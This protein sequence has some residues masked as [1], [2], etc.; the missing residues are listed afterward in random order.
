MWHGTV[1]LPKPAPYP[2]QSKPGPSSP[3][4]TSLAE[5]ILPF[6]HYQIL[7]ILQ[8]LSQVSPPIGSL[9]R[10]LPT[11]PSMVNFYWALTVYKAQFKHLRC[12]NSLTSHIDPNRWVGNIPK[13]WRWGNKWG[14]NHFF[15]FSCHSVTESKDLQKWATPISL[16]KKNVSMNNVNNIKPSHVNAALLLAL[17]L[18][19][20]LFLEAS[21]WLSGQSF[22][23]FFNY[24]P[25]KSA[26]R[27]WKCSGNTM[28]HLDLG[29]L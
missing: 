10:C 20:C 4:N 5:N 22:F 21:N 17:W 29:F 11:I 25:G 15:P 14:N 18:P 9:P 12:M 19:L 8:G 23:F 3:T 6:S 7:L 16:G 24:S 26:I 2:S 27:N 28:T 1:Q 13:I